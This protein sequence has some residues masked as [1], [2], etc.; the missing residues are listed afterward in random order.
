MQWHA[1]LAGD[2]HSDDWAS[3]EFG[4]A[5]LGDARL[6]RRLVALAR[7]LGCA[8]QCPF[9]QS[10][11]PAELK[12]AYRFFD[13]AQVDTNGILAPHI[14]QTLDRMKQVPVVLAVQDTTEFNLAHLSA[15]EGL[16]YCTGSN[17]RG[18]MMHSLLAVTPDGLPL[19]V[20]GM[21]TWV[22]PEAEFGK[23][24][25]RKSRLVHE[26]ESV[27]WL[28]GVEHLASLK[29]RCADTRFVGVGDRESDLFE[30][31]VAER[32]AG[33]DWLIRAS[34]NRRA[35]H[36]D[37]YLW[38][39]VEATR[40]LGRTDLLVPARRNAPQR[41]ARL[42]LRCATVRLR[43][44]KA[45]AS[46]LKEVD[47]FAIH[48]IET[49]PPCGVEPLEWMLLSSV[50]T[51]TLEEVL[52]RLAWYARRWTIE[53]WHR[54]LKS[55]CRIEARQFGNLDRF[56]RATALFT[57]IS[58]RI[59]YATL[60]ARIDTDLPCDVLLQPLEWQ[61]LYCHSND[62]TKLPKQTPSLQQAV[63]WIAMLGGYQNRKHDRPPGPTVLWRGFLVLH[64]ITKMY[65]LCRQ[66]E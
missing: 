17:T 9:P 64:D 44:P 33:V 39:A 60:L 12:A 65:R 37:G 36:P 28:E 43:P 10:L 35:R 57:V 11:K 53:S 26:K 19:G 13:N 27:K 49:S 34:W 50:P 29:T 52:E 23:T 6:V 16:G 66:N 55:G 61:A 54:V 2:N 24:R 21:K 38:E 20:L 15:T 22:R 48:A 47:V 30:L 8:P 5:N 45:R 63:L 51:T 3:A 40:P 25:Q 1:T 32:P 41:T 46:R 4:E 58:W 59:L 42:T 56:V 14:A 31:F 7:R 62:T 18:F